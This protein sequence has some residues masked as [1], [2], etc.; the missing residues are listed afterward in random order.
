MPNQNQPYNMEQWQRD[1]DNKLNSILQLLKGHELD[2][3]DKGL[4]GQTYDHEH[5]IEKLEKLKDRVVNIII[6]LSVPAGIGLYDVL[7]SLAFLIK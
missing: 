5:R 7:K 4:V 3:D 1:I 2:K 6:G